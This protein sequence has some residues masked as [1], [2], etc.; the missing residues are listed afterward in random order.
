MPITSRFPTTADRNALK[1][2]DIF[3][4]DNGG[5][6]ALAMKTSEEMI[7]RVLVLTAENE[8][9]LPALFHA[10]G[11]PLLVRVLAGQ[12]SVEPVDGFGTPTTDFAKPGSIWTAPDGD[13]RIR[14]AGIQGAATWWSLISGL[15]IRAQPEP[16]DITYDKWR[17]VLRRPNEPE[18][19]V[20]R[21]E[22]RPQ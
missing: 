2:G 4:F 18:V 10:A 8:E 1:P 15:Q 5:N 11:L 9:K 22:G 19:E 14:T 3:F 21:W 13:I 17:L 6:Q 20:T 12:I 7:S 16:S